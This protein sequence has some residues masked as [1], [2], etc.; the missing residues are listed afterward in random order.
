LSSFSVTRHRFDGNDAS[1]LSN[2]VR[3]GE[4]HYTL[5]CAE[6]KNASPGPQPVMAQDFDFGLKCTITV[7]PTLA[8]LVN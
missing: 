6:V 3:Q 8:F 5:V 2:E 4:S 7:I 1:S